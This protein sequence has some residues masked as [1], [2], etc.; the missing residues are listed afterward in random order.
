MQQPIKLLGIRP[1]LGIDKC[2]VRSTIELL[3][4]TLLGDKGI[5]R[6]SRDISCA[7]KWYT[8][9]LDDGEDFFYR[10]DRVVERRSKVLCE[11]ALGNGMLFELLQ[12]NSQMNQV[13]R[14]AICSTLIEILLHL[15][16]NGVTLLD[17]AAAQEEIPPHSLGHC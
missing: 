7:R 15:P 3:I 10:A 14:N 13:G 4:R 12:K 5:V 17:S 16:L 6:C 1:G 8:A 9:I 2:N 11:I